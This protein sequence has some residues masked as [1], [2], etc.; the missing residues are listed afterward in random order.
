MEFDKLHLLP[1]F[2]MHVG[3]PGSS[4]AYEIAEKI[5]L[6]HRIVKYAQ[7]KTGKNEKAIDDMLI[8]L[9]SE[10]KEYEDKL[11]SLLEKQDRLDR[12]IQSYEH[13]NADLDI[14]RKR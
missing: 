9:M 11:A 10:K 2:R 8:T 1:T 12:L 7:H 13:M 14:K 5:G 6:D 3:K 4:F